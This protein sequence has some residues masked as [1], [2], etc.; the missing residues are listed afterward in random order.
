[1]RPTVVPQAL[2]GQP[3]Q[4]ADA[5]ALG[6]SWKTLQGS[7]YR[8]VAKGIHVA[9]TTADSHRIRIR[10]HVGLAAWDDRDRRLHLL[11]VDVGSQLPLTFATTH[12]RQVR[13]LR[14]RSLDTDSSHL[15]EPV[16]RA[17]W[18]AVSTRP[19]KPRGM[20]GRRLS[21]ANFGS[22]SSN[23]M[24]SN[25]ARQAR[26]VGDSALSWKCFATTPPAGQ[27]HPGWVMH[28]HRD[29][30]HTADEFEDKK[31]SQEIKE[32]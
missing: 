26:Q 17:N 14:P 11:G 9:T 30:A 12:P 32:M 4:T 23:P 1:M 2:N 15:S 3:F 28:H 19:S 31:P 18:S 29:A 21:S 6:V 25:L 5:F 7:R 13:R 16:G 22:A 24:R 20:T 27:H 8:R 10:G